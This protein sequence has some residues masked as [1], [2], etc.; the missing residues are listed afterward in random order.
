MWKRTGGMNTPW[1]EL[2]RPKPPRVDDI[3]RYWEE[4]PPEP[5]ARCR[6]WL[7][8]IEAGWRPNRR[9]RQM[10]CYGAAEQFGVYIWEYNNVLWPAFTGETRDV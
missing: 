10:G 6:Y 7:D 3:Y 8:Q 2:P 9:W 5:S 4:Q 1:V